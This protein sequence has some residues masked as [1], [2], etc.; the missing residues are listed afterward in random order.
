[1]S[2]Q[3]ALSSPG[4]NPPEAPV[5]PDLALVRTDLANERTLLAYGRTALMIIGTGFSLIQFLEPTP[6]LLIGGWTLIG[7]GGVLGL[8]G[9]HRFTSLRRR[10]H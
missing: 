2:H 5:T 10:L 6:G 9:I 1:M 7:L 3:D 8:V 4:S